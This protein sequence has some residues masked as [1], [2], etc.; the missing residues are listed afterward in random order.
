MGHVKTICCES[1]V[2][3]NNMHPCFQ[4]STVYNS[5]DTGID[6]SLHQHKNEDRI[7]HLYTGVLLSLKKKHE[8]VFQINTSLWFSENN[9]ELSKKK[10]E[11]F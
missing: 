2:D 8:K 9:T 5:Q 11:E 4:G 10:I 1:L 7:V 6:R 3:P